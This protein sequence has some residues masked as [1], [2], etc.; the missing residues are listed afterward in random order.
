MP[1]PALCTVTVVV[2]LVT[3]GALLAAVTV[4]VPAATPV[5]G[6]F[7][8][9]APC[10][11]VTEAGTVAAAG[12]LEL[13]VTAS[14]PTGASEERFSA[15]FC[16]A[17]PGITTFCAA[18]LSAAPTRTIRVAGVYPGADAVM[19]GDP[20]FTPVTCGCCAG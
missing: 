16:V 5:I 11:M 3:F 8:V 15:T 17:A 19:V 14:P 7:T 2:A 1:P 18:K 13:R 10:G 4:A 12:L 6:T 9:E 20:K